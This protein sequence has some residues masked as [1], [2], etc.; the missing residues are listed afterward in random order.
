MLVVRGKMRGKAEFYLNGI[1]KLT[2]V[3]VLT[4]KKGEIDILHPIFSNFA[5]KIPLAA[6]YSLG[7]LL[8]K[9][10]FSF[11]HPFFSFLSI[12]FI[13]NYLLLL[14]QLMLFI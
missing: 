9:K 12:S 8:N 1:W 10:V 7:K 13:P 2:K 6:I 5:D 11:S 4:F 3:V 14:E